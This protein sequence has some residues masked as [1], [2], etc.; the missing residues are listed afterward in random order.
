M[1]EENSN[2]FLASDDPLVY[3]AEPMHEK[4]STKFV[5]VYSFNTRVS[6][7]QCFNSPSLVRT[8]THFG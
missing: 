1:M 2:I 5:W 4:Y 8:C 3:L 6:Y 7:D